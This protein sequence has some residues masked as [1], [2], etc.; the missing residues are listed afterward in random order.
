[1]ACN[2][3]MCTGSSLIRCTDRP[4]QRNPPP[5]PVAGHHLHRLAAI[6]YQ[7]TLVT[8]DGAGGPP[9][10]A[11]FDR[12]IATCSIP[13]VPWEWVEQSRIWC[14]LQHLLTAAAMNLTRPNAWR[15]DTPRPHPNIPLRGTQQRRDGFASQG[16]GHQRAGALGAGETRTPT[17]RTALARCRKFESSAGNV[18][19]GRATAPRAGTSACAPT[20]SRRGRER[21][22][23]R[24]RESRESS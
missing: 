5:A 7:P 10:H 4:V 15:T 18:K 24:R 20:H 13:A 12:I 11:P 8:V 19:T 1:M 17:E 21:R 6:G 9:D 14:R 23:R 22:A 16:L 3:T 2:F